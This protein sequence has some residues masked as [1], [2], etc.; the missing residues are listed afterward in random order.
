[1]SALTCGFIGLGLIGGSIA[2]AIRLNLPDTKIIAYDINN[3]TL[4]LAK[5]EG[6]ADVILEKIDDTFSECNYVFLCAPVSKNDE[7]VKTLV[8]FINKD[9]TAISKNLV[10]PLNLSADIPWPEANVS[11]L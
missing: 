9:C 4:T 11:A 1:M 2:K 7:N 6:I 3:D 5:S 8:E 10:C